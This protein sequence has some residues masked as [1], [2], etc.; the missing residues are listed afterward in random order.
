[1]KKAERIHTIMRFI[2]NRAHFTISEIMD[3]FQLSRSTAVRDIREIEALGFPLVAEVGRAGGYSVINNAMLPPVHFTNDE[4]KAL[5]VALLATK[6]RQL[7]FLKSR[8]TLTEKLIGLLSHSQQDDLILLNKIL[9][10]QGTN[11]ANP[12]LLDLSDLPHPILEKLI[13][14]LFES[15]Y[16]TLQTK[17][18]VYDVYINHLYQEFSQWVIEASDLNLK[19]IR[20]I[21][22][23]SLTDVSIYYPSR[24]FHEKDLASYLNQHRNFYNLLL[25][26]GPKSVIQYHKYHPFHVPVSY[27]DPFQRTGICKIEVDVT[28]EEELESIC[29]WIL[30]LGEELIIEEAPQEIHRLLL[31]RSNDQR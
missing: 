16:L 13:K 7:P 1:M 27:T 3:E 26:L 18:A 6:N 25:K 22:V 14:A 12:D 9:R 10:F 5:F 29:N 21:G 23:A 2:N 15:R 24:T 8:M 11:P 28:N 19:M 31:H 4:V 30:F 17:D 20:M